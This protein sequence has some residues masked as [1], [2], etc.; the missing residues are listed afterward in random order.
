MVPGGLVWQNTS[1]SQF[2]INCP[3]WQKFW[4]HTFTRVINLF[5]VLLLGLS[6]SLINLLKGKKKR[7]FT[8]IGYFQI[9]RLLPKGKML[10]IET[11]LQIFG[12]KGTIVDRDN[13]SNRSYTLVGE[14]SKIL[15]Q[16]CVDLKLCHTKVSHNLEA[17]PFPPIPVTSSLKSNAIPSSTN[18]M[19]STVEKSVKPDVIVTRSGH[20]VRPPNRFKF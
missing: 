9:S 10:G 15:S 12:E 14:N 17:K 8:M 18:A 6:Q 13:T 3:V 2:P 4:I 7:N 1:V 20:T 16:N 19:Q 11:M 5:C